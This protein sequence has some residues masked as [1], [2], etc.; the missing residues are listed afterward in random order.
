M[1]LKRRNFCS[2]QWPSACEAVPRPNMHRSMQTLKYIFDHSSYSQFFWLWLTLFFNEGKH[3]QSGW[4]VQDQPVSKPLFPLIAVLYY[5]IT[6]FFH[7]AYCNDDIFW[8][9]RWT[10]NADIFAPFSGTL[11]LNHIFVLV[12]TLNSKLCIALLFLCLPTL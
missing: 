12:C 10:W 3:S 9:T 4:G 6:N 8:V 2:F 5:R 11:S 1:N 7:V